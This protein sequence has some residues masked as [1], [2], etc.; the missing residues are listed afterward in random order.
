[1]NYPF[2]KTESYWQKKWEDKKYP[3][4]PRPSK[5]KYI[6]EMLPYPSGKIHM[7]HVR[8]YSIGDAIARFYMMQGFDVLHPMGFDAFGLPA[9]NA[10]IERGADPSIWTHNNIKEMSANLKSLGFSYDWTREFATCDVSYYKHEQQFFI[11][12]Y[13]KGLIY[14][15]E[16]FVN[17]DPVEQ[18]VLANEQVINGRGW[19]SGALVERKKL[20]QWF[21]KITHYAEELLAELPNL[22]WPEKVLKM[23]ENWIGKSQ[24]A[25]IKFSDDIMVY[26]TRPETIFGASFIALS[27]VHPICLKL[28]ENNSDLQKFIEEFKHA[29]T[30]EAA[31]EKQEKKG[32]NLNF[33]VKHPFD[34]D[35]DI[36][37]YA[38][39]FVVMDYGTGSLFGCP[40]HDERDFEFATKYHLPI[41][42]VIDEHDKMIDSDFLTNLFSK[43]AVLEVI[44]KLEEKGLGQSQT[45]YRLRDWGVSRQRYWGCPIPMVYCEQC[46]VIPADLPV[47]LPLDIKITGKGNPLDHHPTWKHTTCPKCHEKAIRETDT[48]DTFFE[49][50]WYF[51]RYCCPNSEKPLEHID[52]WMPVDF[53]IGGIEHAVM[54]LLYARFFMKA[55]CDLGYSK[56]REP[57]QTLITQGMVCHKTYQTKDGKFLYPQELPKD[58]SAV[59]IGRSEKMSKSKR[60]TVDPEDILKAYGA[61]VARLFVLSDT[62]IDKDFDWNEEGLEGC[63]RYINKIWRLFEMIIS[64]HPEHSEGSSEHTNLGIGPFAIA[65][66]DNGGL[67]K[68]THKFIKTITEDYNKQFFNKAIAHHREFVRDLEESYLT[69]TKESVMEALKVMILTLSPITPHITAE[70]LNKMTGQESDV[71]PIYDEN[72]VEDDTMNIVVQVNGK[73]RGEFRISK[74]TQE[75]EIIDTAKHMAAKYLENKEIKK[76]I[77]IKEKMVSVACN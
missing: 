36:P 65:Q 69:G 15:K 11:E 29:P 42:K 72:L 74:D 21:L 56:I 73:K 18:T 10:A 44:K 27:P 2:K 35:W 30:T 58:M 59:T 51:L 50:S 47:E 46:G 12:L 8:N 9:E 66:G 1:M 57:F 6:L 70:M 71:W 67:T 77:Y 60:N 43:Q 17:F 76:V 48:L 52:E 19:R 4:L 61:D 22:N 41:K 34:S 45:Q 31:L 38:A 53:Y 64:C 39:N 75:S 26:T 14:Q 37:V 62:P 68:I 49:S 3:F 40:A 28:A 24:G 54:H 13:K 23:Q 63:Y 5:K 32:F 33:T 16:S 7:G 20:R 25:L 55:L